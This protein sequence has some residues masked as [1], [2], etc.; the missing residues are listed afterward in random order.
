MF[1]LQARSTP[2]LCSLPCVLCIILL[3]CPH[4]PRSRKAGK[5][6]SL[7]LEQSRV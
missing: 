5:D 6:A 3:M 4:N 1:R 7:D 2:P